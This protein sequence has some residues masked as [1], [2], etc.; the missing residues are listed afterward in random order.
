MDDYYPFG[1]TFNSYQRGNSVQQD[2][3][4]NSMEFQD[5]LSLGWYDYLARQYDPTIGRFSSIDPAADL[6]RRVAPYA[7]AFNNPVR[8][9]DPD[10]MLPEDRTLTVE[11]T[12]NEDTHTD[13]VSETTKE[14]AVT[15]TRTVKRG[16]KE[17][18][19]TL[20]RSD[21]TSNNG[22]GD[23]IV[24]TTT[25]HTTTNVTTT[26]NYD[27]EGNILSHST[28]S[29]IET[30]TTTS[31][32]V[33]GEDGKPS[34]GFMEKT[35]NVVF[36]DSNL[37]HSEN[38]SGLLIDAVVHRSLMGTSINTQDRLADTIAKGEVFTKAAY[39]AEGAWGMAG[40][41]LVSK[42]TYVG[43]GLFLRGTT[44]AAE[45]DMARLRKR[46]DGCHNCKKNY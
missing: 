46:S 14:S 17:F 22:I 37:A 9:I 24:V 26:L 19:T 15:S 12:D 38:G 8:F 18:D 23:E 45:S 35:D 31:Y 13:V 6:M 41:M 21:I 36:Q 32:T 20:G 42:P 10:G 30:Y 2:Y 27:A 7:Y 16:T 11:S 34:G 5:E 33:M 28:T 44:T 4:Y 25:Q 1:L 29:S 43:V 3:L 39:T 40:S